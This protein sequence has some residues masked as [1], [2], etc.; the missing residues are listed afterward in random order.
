GLGVED[1]GEV[2]APGGANLDLDQAD[3]VAAAVGAVLPEADD[4]VSDGGRGDEHVLDLEG[5]IDLG[6]GQE[7][8]AVLGEPVEEGEGVV[9]GVEHEQAPRQFGGRSVWCG[10]RVVGSDAQQVPQGRQPALVVRG[11]GIADPDLDRELARE[12]EYR[13]ALATG[14]GCPGPG[15]LAQ[16]PDLPED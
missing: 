6:A 16:Q 14:G 7:A 2:G 13:R 5:G 15:T 3:A 11:R 10:T 12:V 1:I 8:D 4:T 9:A